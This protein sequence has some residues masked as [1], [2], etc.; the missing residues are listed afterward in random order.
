M[1]ITR[2][3]IS[4]STTAVTATMQAR[5]WLALIGVGLPLVLPLAAAGLA[6]VLGTAWQQ[7]DGPAAVTDFLAYYTGGR[8]LV[9]YPAGLYDHATV[10]A[11]EQ[12]LQGGAGEYLPY[13]APPQAAV[14]MAPL[15]RLG[16]GQ[17]YLVW[18]LAGLVSLA[19]SAW[20]LAPRLWGRWS[21]LVWLAA[22]PLFLPVQETFLRGQTSLLSLLATCLVI[23]GVL[24]SPR[25]GPVAGVLPLT[26][27][28]QMLPVYVLALA[29]DRRW[30]LLAH[31]GGVTVLVVLPALVWAGPDV[32]LA[33]VQT[34][35]DGVSAAGAADL[36]AG[37]SLLGLWQGWLGTGTLASV[38]AV[39]SGAGALGLQAW[40]WRGGLRSDARRWL[41]LAALPLLAVLASPHALYYEMTTWLASAW[42]LLQY[43]EVEPDARGPVRLTLVVGW[44]LSTIELLPGWNSSTH[45]GTVAGLVALGVISWLFRAGATDDRSAAR[46]RGWLPSSGWRPTWR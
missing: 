36:P 13:L 23:R 26:W 18:G 9:E 20:L 6:Q 11:V 25:L 1:R 40:L 12:A 21:W 46:S 41:Q 17:A 30:H 24:G 38:L 10:V 29:L 39:S 32:L 22:A 27:K 28:P 37:L 15:A 42:L 3:G 34:M 43:T 35:R 2:S 19:M 44:L 33:F 8:L 31:L 45:W 14:L 16:Y 4:A 5:A 7:L